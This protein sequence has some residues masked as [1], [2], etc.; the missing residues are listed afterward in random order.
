MVSV[1]VGRLMYA[2]MKYFDL[3]QNGAGVGDGGEVLL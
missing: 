2:T 1:D 3:V